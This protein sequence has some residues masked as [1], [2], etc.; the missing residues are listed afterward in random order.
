MLFNLEKDPTQ[1]YDI[2]DQEP[3]LA[4]ALYQKFIEY[5]HKIQALS[6]QIEKYVP[7]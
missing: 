1:Q 4:D 2:I 5:L 3:E 6:D 7:Y